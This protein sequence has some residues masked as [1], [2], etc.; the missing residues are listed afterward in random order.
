M[1]G[2]R[3]RKNYDKKYEPLSALDGATVPLHRGYIY[4]RHGASGF[5]MRSYLAAV[6]LYKYT[7]TCVKSVEG[8][9]DLEC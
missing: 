1:R 7:H 8:G 5:K 9:I 2:H 3:D 6:E 4:I